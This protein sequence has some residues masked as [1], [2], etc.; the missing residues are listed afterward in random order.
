MPATKAAAAAAVTARGGALAVSGVDGRSPGPGVW[1]QATDTGSATA[2]GGGIANTGFIGTLVYKLPRS[3]S[4][5]LR[6]A[7]PAARAVPTWVVDRAEARRAISAVCSRR[8]GAVGITTAL[9]GAGGFGKTTLAQM[10]CAD[11]RVRRR[12]SGGVYVVTVG[13]DVRGRAAIAAKVAAAITYITNDTTALPDPEQ[14]GEHLGRLLDQ[15][16]RRRRILLVLDDLWEQEQLDPF[17]VGGSRCTRLVTTRVPV[18]LPP[19]AQR[20][21]VDQMTAEQARAVLAW[22]LPPIRE[23]VIQGLLKA[24]GRWP[25]LLRLTNRTIAVQVATGADP[26]E[27]AQDTLRRLRERGPTAVDDPSLVLDLDDPKQ[28]RKMVRATVQAATTLL[29]AGGQERFAELGIFAEDEAVPVSLVAKLWHATG[30]LDEAGTRRLCKSLDDLS[31]L[32]VDPATGGRLSLHDTIRDYLRR[33]LGPQYLITLNR[34]LLDAVAADL[35]TALPLAPSV[36]PPRTAWW[37][38]TGGYLL[39]HTVAHLLAADRTA[40]AEVVACDL[41]WVEARLRQRGPTAPWADCQQIP[42]ATAATRARELARTAHL[43]GPTKPAHALTTILHSRL[44]PLHNWHDQVTARQDQLTQPALLNHWTPPDLPHPALQR[45]ITG[46]TDRVTGVAISPDGTWLATTSNDSTVRVWDR[47]TGRQT[48]TL[49]GHTSW[50]KRVAIS[51][52]GTWLATTSNDSTVRVWDRGTGRQTATLTGHTDWVTGVAI[53]PDGTWLA[54]TSNDSTVRVWDRGTGRQT[55]TL[56][57]HTGSVRGVAISPD[58]TWLATSGSDR[59]V[60]VWDRGTGRLTATLTGH[61]D[62]VRG[63]AISPDG[64]WLATTSDDSTVRVWD[65][66]TGRQTATLTGHTDWVRGVA[67]SPDGTWLATSGSDRT[68]RVWDRGTGRQ[69]AT[70]TGHA[71]SVRGVAISPDGT[72]LATTSDGTVRV[73]GRGTGRQTA[74]LTGHTDRVTGVAISPDGTWLAT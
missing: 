23:E 67:I 72:W 39:D 14:A 64:T 31:L 45:T 42:T 41:R 43:L 70:L 58:G 24:T 28:R 55:A 33:E 29:P 65:R 5:A 11:R 20:I 22:E 48:A 9:A 40:Q 10:V 51:P 59:T 6:L 35:P 38:L 49:T 68:V 27:A 54:T 16:A 32:A 21:P 2:S 60:R 46:H 3:V 63:V 36:P 12:F 13:R 8:G 30:G 15:L 47:A 57:G 1:V 71:G 56:T 53:S 18:I 74:T 26:S 34:V 50:V 62:W 73:W 4:R 69:T 66:G 44:E 52:D 17:L 7:P 19:G 61:T 25:Q 37:E